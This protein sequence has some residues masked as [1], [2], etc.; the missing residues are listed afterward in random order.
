MILLILIRNQSPVAATYY[1]VEYLLVEKRCKSKIYQ[2]IK[3]LRI[4]VVGL[5][6]LDLRCENGSDVYLQ[7]H[8]YS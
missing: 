7:Q 2:I 5:L 3:Q 8:L 6:L 4:M 1:H